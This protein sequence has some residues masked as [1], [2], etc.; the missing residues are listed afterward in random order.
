MK[1]FLVVSVALLLAVA[2]AAPAMA[3]V[4]FSYGGQ[5]RVRYI[6]QANFSTPIAQSFAVTG[7]N[8]RDGATNALGDDLSRFDERLRLYFT[9]TASENLKLV[10]KFEVGDVIWG[11]PGT[12]GRGC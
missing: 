1:K 5:F 3:K 12:T 11:N 10:T 2:V 6:G 9:F 4:E 8:A 7:P